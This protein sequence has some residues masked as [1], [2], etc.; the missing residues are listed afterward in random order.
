ME[1]QYPQTLTKLWQYQHGNAVLEFDA[2]A[3]YQSLLATVQ[4]A[5]QSCSNKED[6]AGDFLVHLWNGA[7]PVFIRSRSILIAQAKKFAAKQNNLVQYELNEILHDALITLEKQGIIERDSA[8][9]GHRISFLT[10]FAFKGTPVDKKGTV[11]DYGKN[12]GQVGFFC[13]RIRND[14]PEKTRLLAPKDA[15][16]LIKQLLQA[17]GGWTKKT[18]L[19]YAMQNHIPPQMRMIAVDNQFSVLSLQAEDD[20]YDAFD[21]EFDV[22]QATDEV[23]STRDNIWKKICDENR[24]KVFCFYSLPTFDGK[25]VRL[26]DIGKTSTISDQNTKIRSIMQDELKNY[27]NSTTPGE[28]AVVNKIFKELNGKCTDSGYD[29]DLYVQEKSTKQGE[30]CND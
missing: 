25:E 6:M 20:F 2:N 3:A 21:N 11:E 18:D 14:D 4:G 26:K 30:S 13:A 5:F 1:I 28:K 16:L 7:I 24:E 19:F 8:S 17:F 10:S 23:E 12:K 27:Q 9:V 22:M 15:Q 29:P